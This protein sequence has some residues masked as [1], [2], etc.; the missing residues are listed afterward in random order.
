M[1]TAQTVVK[2]VGLMVPDV[3]ER[4]RDRQPFLHLPF[5]FRLSRYSP[6]LSTGTQV[7]VLLNTESDGVANVTYSLI[8]ITGTSKGSLPGKARWITTSVEGSTKVSCRQT[9]FPFTYLDIQVLHNFY[10]IYNSIYNSI[11]ESLYK[12][13]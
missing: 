7:T 3:S 10:F 13:I 6:K 11:F 12:T 9:L 8:I 2:L 1:L 5:H 4:A